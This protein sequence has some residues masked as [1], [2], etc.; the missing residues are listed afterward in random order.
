[1][2]SALPPL[3]RWGRFS[4]GYSLVQTP[5]DLPRNPALAVVR[6]TQTLRYSLSTFT[7]DIDGKPK[8]VFRTKWHAD[9]DELCRHWVQSHQDEVISKG[10]YGTDLPPMVRVRM[11]RLAEKDTYD[12]GAESAELYLEV[13]IV[14]LTDA[15]EL[16]DRT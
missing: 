12:A 7:L 5:L 3:R 1:M 14:R 6:D 10:P 4:P 9:A 15:S 8:L 2:A 11:A 13:R 16:Q